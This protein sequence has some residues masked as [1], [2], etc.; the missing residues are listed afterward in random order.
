MIINTGR[1]DRRLSTRAPHR[2]APHRTAPRRAAPRAAPRPWATGPGPPARCWAAAGGRCWAAA[3]G[4]R[5]GPP[6]GRGYGPPLGQS[7]FVWGYF[8]SRESPFA[9]REPPM[10][11]GFSRQTICGSFTGNTPAFHV[12]FT[13]KEL[14]FT[15]NNLC[16]PVKKR[17]IVS[18]EKKF[19]SREPRSS[20]HV[21]P[22]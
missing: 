5:R 13:G 1:H 14:F 21:K 6:L 7:P 3:G 4:R 2:T 10:G 20:F 11:P 15:G 12:K 17:Q 18:R 19:L 9:S 22:T 16:F 8:V